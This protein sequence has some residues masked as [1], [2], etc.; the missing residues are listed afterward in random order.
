MALARA[1]RQAA[2]DVSTDLTAKYFRALGDPTR[3]RILEMLMDGPLTVSDLTREL[4]RPQSNISNHIACLR[5]CGFVESEHEGK[6]TYYA[7]T[8][9]KIRRIVEIARDLVSTNAEHVA[10]C[11]RIASR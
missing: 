6:W 3:L 10:A 7:V 5:W 2:L 9:P 11:T 1:E 8:D 4:Q